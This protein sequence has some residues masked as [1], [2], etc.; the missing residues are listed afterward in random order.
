MEGQPQMAV[1]ALP[2]DSFIKAIADV[3]GVQKTCD[4][5]YRVFYS[6]NNFVEFIVV[7]INKLKIRTYEKI[8]SDKYDAHGV[9]TC[10]VAANR[11]SR[12]KPLSRLRFGIT[13]QNPEWKFIGDK[14][15][16]IDFYADWCKPCKMIAPHLEEIQSEYGSKLTH[17]KSTQTIPQIWQIYSKSEASRHYC[18]SQLTVI[19]N[20]LWAIGIKN[21]LLNW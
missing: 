3:L 7:H 17:T 20:K 13:K 9:G 1:G 6:C 8:H 10:L 15:M 11:I 19:F 14:P 18:L 4:P 2:K 16:I 12:T 5:I 21:S